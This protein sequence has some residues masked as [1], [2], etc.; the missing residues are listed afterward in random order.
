MAPLVESWPSSSLPDHTH[1]DAGGKF[2]K[3]FNG[4]LE[5]C[6]LLEMVQYVCEVERPQVRESKALCW[7]IERLFRR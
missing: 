1:A 6:E 7:P 5:Q 4:K 3:G 2:R